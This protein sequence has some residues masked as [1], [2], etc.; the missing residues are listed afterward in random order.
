MCIFPPKK[1]AIPKLSVPVTQAAICAV[2][3]AIDRRFGETVSIREIARR[4]SPARPKTPQHETDRKLLQRAMRSESYGRRMQKKTFDRFVILLER[5]KKGAGKRLTRV[6]Q[7]E[8]A[9]RVMTQ[10]YR[11][12]DW[13]EHPLEPKELQAI[14]RSL[15]PEARKRIAAFRRRARSGGHDKRRIA[16]AVRRILQPPACHAR[17]MGIERGW[18]EFNREEQDDFIKWGIGRE[19]IL[20]R[21]SPAKYRAIDRFPV[22]DRLHNEDL[23]FVLNILPDD[24]LEKNRA[25]ITRAIEKGWIRAGLWEGVG[26][27]RFERALLERHE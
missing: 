14:Q 23:E 18:H 17:T 20:L 11:D 2:Q 9:A 4:V 15:S 6:I 8:R 26:L 13:A 22:D 3:N 27:E 7:S 12:T 19:R 25:A 21:T 10:V 5:I 1:M 16:L 24:I